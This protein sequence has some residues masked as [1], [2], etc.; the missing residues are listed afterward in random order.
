VPVT[1]TAPSVN[2][3]GYIMINKGEALLKSLNIL[4][5]IYK[6]DQ[7]KQRLGLGSSGSKAKGAALK[8]QEKPE[9][10]FEFTSVSFKVKF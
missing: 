10:A 7:E 4:I 8:K 1:V 6:R 5:R 9:P 3:G 2:H